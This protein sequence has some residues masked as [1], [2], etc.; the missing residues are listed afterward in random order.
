M[1]WKLIKMF[2]KS[3]R[4]FCKNIFYYSHMFSKVNSI[5]FFRFCKQNS[6]IF[7]QNCTNRYLFFSS[8]N[9]AILF[10]LLAFS[11]DSVTFILIYIFQFWKNSSTLTWKSFHHEME[12]WGNRD[13]RKYYEKYSVD[14][15]AVFSSRCIA[16]ITI[17]WLN[18]IFAHTQ[19]HL[20]IYPIST[21]ITSREERCG[22][23]E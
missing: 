2:H 17:C 20:W 13:G 8:N 7:N 9:F 4:T 16:T 21:L 12:N 14:A 6:S 5:L 15:F 18:I 22:K 19:S 3:A 1:K 10:N 11:F 23:Y